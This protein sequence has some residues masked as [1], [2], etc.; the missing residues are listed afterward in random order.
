MSVS[1]TSESL[2]AF[3]ILLQSSAPG[4]LGTR[5]HHRLKGRGRSETKEGKT[6]QAS[7]CLKA[8][9]RGC[10]YD[11]SCPW[12]LT[13]LLQTT[14]FVVVFL[15]RR[16]A[17]FAFKNASFRFSPLVV[18]IGI[19]SFPTPAVVCAPSRPLFYL[20]PSL[21]SKSRSRARLETSH[22]GYDFAR[23]LS[24]RYEIRGSSHVLISLEKVQTCIEVGHSSVRAVY[25]DVDNTN[26]DDDDDDD[27][28][29]DSRDDK[30]DRCDDNNTANNIN[31]AALTTICSSSRR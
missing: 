13:L 12:L 23:H 14:A 10:G 11:P 24:L 20:P 25:D 31:G 8:V 16:P 30:S 29:A 9:C 4:P 5:K 3:R 15:H 28:D 22:G 6:K 18:G 7:I 27:E 26:D 21:L 17:H 2:S 19:V 1:S